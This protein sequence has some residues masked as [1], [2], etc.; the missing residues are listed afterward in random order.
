VT[1]PARGRRFGLAGAALPSATLGADMA[2]ARDAG[3]HALELPAE[4]L[5]LQ[6]AQGRTLADVRATLAEA[7]LEPLCLYGAAE[8]T[9]VIGADF[10]GDAL[11][12]RTRALCASAVGIGC[13]LVAAHLGVDATAVT[14][15]LQ[16]MGAVARDYGARIG[17][18]LAGHCGSSVRT[19]AAARDI[20]AGAGDGAVG[21]IIDAFQLHAGASTW[22]MLEGL[23]PTSLCLVRL[24][25]APAVPLDHLTEADRLLPGDGAIALLTLVRLLD[26]LGYGGPYSVRVS[27]SAYRGW[28]APALARAARE[29]LA[30]LFAE[31]DEQQGRLD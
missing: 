11:L 21:L 7:G 30:A 1:L 26:G 4:K 6:L 15:A 9:L 16:A 29:S 25:D 18:E 27:R 20:V 12:E 17:L 5:A 10:D 28:G 24:A 14:G 13:P 2:V 23:D 3:F 22:A 31:L 19:V 8:P